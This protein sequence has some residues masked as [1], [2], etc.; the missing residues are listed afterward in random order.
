MLEYQ[1]ES[2][3]KTVTVLE[4][5]ARSADVALVLSD[6]PQLDT[7]GEYLSFSFRVQYEQGN[8]GIED[9]KRA[10]SHSPW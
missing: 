5:G 1:Q 3:I 2:N 6:A 7:A 9:V 10:A 4:R 8:P